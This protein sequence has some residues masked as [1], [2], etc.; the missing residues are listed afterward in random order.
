MNTYHKIQ[1]V[2]YRNPEDNYKTLLMGEFA[3]PEF[4]YL[5]NNKWA[6]TEKVDGTNIRVQYDGNYPNFNGK[7]DTS[8]MPSTLFNHLKDRFLP[9]S[10]KFMDTFGTEDVKVCLY[11]EGYGPRIQKGGGN[12]REDQSFV[13]FDVKINDWWL[14]REDVEDI[15]MK[16]KIDVVP[17]IGYGTLYEAVSYV[18]QGFKSQWSGFRSDFLAEGIVARPFVELK[19][20]NG[21]RII[22]KIKYKDFVR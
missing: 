12:Y 20:R 7:K 1:S 13:L 2:F 6:W 16:F 4:E 5:A 11:G 21:E 8:Q 17:I 15:G 18:E 19:A 3:K 10:E 14:K 9:Q 22:T